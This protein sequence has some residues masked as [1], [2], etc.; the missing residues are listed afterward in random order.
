MRMGVVVAAMVLLGCERKPGDSFEGNVLPVGSSG[1]FD[2]P[3]LVLPPGASGHA[4]LTYPLGASRT[5]SVQV[6]G[7]SGATPP[8]VVLGTCV[9]RA[10]NFV[11]DVKVLTSLE[12]SVGTTWTLQVEPSDR[13]MAPL[14]VVMA[15]DPLLTAELETSFKD[16]VPTAQAFLGTFVALSGDATLVV[17]ASS[18]SS[19]LTSQRHL[20]RND[21]GWYEDATISSAWS[22]SSIALSGNGS[23]LA[24][25]A[26]D[27]GNFTSVLALT[28]RG[29]EEE[30]TANAWM[31]LELSTDG[32]WLWGLQRG[33]PSTPNGFEVLMT[34]DAGAWVE[35]FRT[36]YGTPIASNGST[37]LSPR[38]DAGAPTIDVYGRSS[39]QWALESSF[40]LPMTDWVTSYVLSADGE[41]FLVCDASPSFPGAVYP[42]HRIGG[43][44]TPETPLRPD[45]GVSSA[46]FGFQCRLS[47]DGS[48][49]IVG[50]PTDGTSFDGGTIGPGAV[51]V[52]TRHGSS[53]VRNLRLTWP[54]A[55]TD[56]IFGTAL[57]V[58]ADGRQFLAGMG[59]SSSGAPGINQDLLAPAPSMSGAGVLYRLVGPGS[60][61]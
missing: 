4:T 11:C 42:F 19:T 2:P 3:R 60:Q 25:S 34:L 36:P 26:N 45:P 35:T 21:G 31:P 7:T 9:D 29:W 57:A 47:S 22:P 49:L 20:W 10:P 50:A 8:Q 55:A 30:S 48:R 5:F 59:G 58:S 32:T 39:G 18:G 51:Y 52:F 40:P 28:S 14:E 61:P 27:G 24:V 1:V 37:L 56:G 43:A 16:S 13:A 44:W 54:Q 6:R 33:P 38:L 23:R 15:D 46:E 41:T 12:T 17:L 53:W